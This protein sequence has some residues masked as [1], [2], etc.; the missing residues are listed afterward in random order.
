[1]RLSIVDLSTRVQP[2]FTNNSVI[3]YNGKVYNYIEIRK[4]LEEAEIKFKSTCDKE[5]QNSCLS[6]LLG[7]DSIVVQRK[8]V[9]II[10]RIV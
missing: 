10:I 6:R 2:F 5:V 7:S 9:L 8:G 1:M 3:T 4:D